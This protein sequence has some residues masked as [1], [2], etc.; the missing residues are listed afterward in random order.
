MLL[1]IQCLSE[2]HKLTLLFSHSHRLYLLQPGTVQMLTPLT[3]VHPLQSTVATYSSERIP[4]EPSYQA[5]SDRPFYLNH[6]CT[7]DCLKRIRPTRPSLHRGRN[8]LLTPLLYEFRRMTGRRR[9]NRKVR[10]LEANR[11]LIRVF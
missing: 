4:Q 11:Q 10:V 3:P 9:L 6:I 7:P 8:P 5:P 1:K 2:E